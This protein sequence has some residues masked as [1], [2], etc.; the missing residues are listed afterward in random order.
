MACRVWARTRATVVLPATGGPVRTITRPPA[1]V[2]GT[3]AAGSFTL[4]T[5]PGARNVLAAIGNTYALTL[6]LS[7]DSRSSNPYPGVH[8]FLATTW[9]LT[10]QVFRGLEAEQL[11]SR[12]YDRRCA[13][14]ERLERHELNRR[15]R[16]MAEL[17]PG[18]RPIPSLPAGTDLLPQIKHLVVLMIEDHPS[19]RYLRML[20]PPA[21]PFTLS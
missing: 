15:G 2:G 21:D 1:S 16:G 10:C 11:G 7:K 6:N 18:E 8:Y 14:W 4:P 12:F 5:P 3:P 13:V 9:P 20:P 17:R 19:D